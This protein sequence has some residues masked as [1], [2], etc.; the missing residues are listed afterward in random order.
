LLHYQELMSSMQ[1]KSA[2]NLN[3]YDKKPNL[4][5]PWSTV[6]G[7]LLNADLQ[8]AGLKKNLIVAVDL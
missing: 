4:K 5:I 8:V 1:L 7:K 6:R 2:V 3:V